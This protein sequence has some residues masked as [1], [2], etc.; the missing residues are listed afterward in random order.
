MLT[1]IL[2]LGL[3]LAQSVGDFRIV[4]D[5]TPLKRYEDSDEVSTT[6][7]A[8]AKV[9]VVAVGKTLVRVRSGRDFGWID[10]GKLGEVPKK[11]D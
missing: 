4:S 10:P 6:A 1:L 5:D 9:E 11:G 8:G 2:T 3:A 7:K